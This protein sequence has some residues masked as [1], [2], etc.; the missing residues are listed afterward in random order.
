VEENKLPT[1]SSASEVGETA[2]PTPDASGGLRLGDLLVRDGVVTP[3]QL[4]HALDVQ[5]AVARPLGSLVERLFGVS[6]CAVGAAWAE[7]FAVLHGERNVSEQV[8]DPDC[9]SLLTPRQ[10]WQFRLVP[11]RRE[12]T[13]TG[14]GGHL[15][16][17][18]GR[19]G[20]RK[21]I[22]FAVRTLPISPS[23]ILADA[24][25]LEVLLARYY[26]VPDHIRRWAMGR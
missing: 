3:A 21:T 24:A 22:N 20:L 6:P 9:V 8:C 4:A 19:Q 17:A 13:D 7:Q 25:S 26:P 15:L 14:S 2:V 23:L 12:L 1:S 11:L 18:G 5:A 16:V 10:A